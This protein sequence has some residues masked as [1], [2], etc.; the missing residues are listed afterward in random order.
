M[1]ITYNGLS[2]D[3][4][5]LTFC[6]VPNIL[7]LKQAI[8]GSKCIYNFIVN[9]PFQSTVV[10]DGQYY[11]TFL[12]ETITNVMNPKDARNKRFY[13]A[14]DTT[15]TAASIAQAMR[16]CPSI[17]AQ[18]NVTQEG[19]EVELQAKTYGQKYTNV[20]HYLDTNTNPYIITE[21][22]DGTVSP[23]DVYMSKV[24]VD[25]GCEGKYV[26]TLEK[27]FYGNECAFDMSPVMTTFAEIGKTKDYE[28]IIN[29]IGQNGIASFRGHFSGVTTYG[30]NANQ[31]DKFKYANQDALLLNTNRDQLRFVY[32]NT[33]DYSLYVAD[34]GMSVS[35]V[36]KNAAKTQIYS[37]TVS[38][39]PSSDDHIAD[40]TFTIPQNV[41]TLASWVEITAAGKTVKFK[42]IKPLKA[43]E[44]YQRVYWRNEY[45]G[46]EF[47][48]FTGSKSE[49]DSVDIETYEKNIFDI[50]ENP[51]YEIKK[52]YA[53]DYNKQV[54]LESHLIEA[55]GRYFA[56][57]LMRSKKV[58]TIINKG[59]QS[60]KL[61]YI[62]PKNIDVQEDGT[63]NDIYTVK[64]TYEY[65][66]LS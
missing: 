25:V 62:I 10:S 23:A 46:V 54:K 47:F 17:V 42:V 14:P 45:G 34:G 18:F 37:D 7:K 28:Y 38:I 13:I 3:N 2:T 9:T 60:E 51:E 50:Y 65:S 43:T 11:I 39:S 32:G 35:Y 41:Y 52:I 27:T 36:I 20:P 26:T 5:L 64:L 58:W 53:N 12:D 6:D 57:S 24:L 29:T 8:G 59:K 48:D 16:C 61:H 30:Y 4:T 15:S 56:N 63:Y 1:D 49:S 55:E 40:V 44:Y 33:I 19:N 31:S 21:G 22:T 66:Q